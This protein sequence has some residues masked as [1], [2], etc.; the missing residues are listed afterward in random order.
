MTAEIQALQAKAAALKQKEIAGVIGRMK[1][2]IE[3]YGITAS[4]LG[5]SDAAA[6]PGKAPKQRPTKLGK[7]SKGDRQARYGDG[8]GHVWSGMGPRPTWLKDAIAA[9][10]SLE[11]FA[12]S[13]AAD[14]SVVRAS[15]KVASKLP[16]KYKDDAGNSW[17]GRGSTPRW[18]KAALQ[19]GKTLEQLAA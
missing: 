12:L 3:F 15:A 2:A 13:P 4:D 8:N 5:F 11:S 18:I 9:G 7:P 6:S 1:A 19:D 16:A 17:S 10:R 14:A